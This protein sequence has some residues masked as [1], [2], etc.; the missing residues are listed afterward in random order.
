MR[1]IFDAE[2]A[3]ACGVPLP[4]GALIELPQCGLVQIHF[5]PPAADATPP[6]KAAGGAAG[7]LLLELGEVQAAY[8]GSGTFKGHVDD[9][10]V[11][12]DALEDL[13][14][15]VLSSRERRAGRT[16][17]RRASMCV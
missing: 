3:C 16:T 12:A 10:R 15:C 17:S 14:A 6:S 5:D 2:T 13:G 8:S 1:G 9:L 4:Q 11:E 7:V